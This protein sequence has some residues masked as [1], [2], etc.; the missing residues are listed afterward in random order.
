[1]VNGEDK[2]PVGRLVGC[3]LSAY[4]H[5]PERAPHQLRDRYSSFSSSMLVGGVVSSPDCLVD[6]SSHARDPAGPSSFDV[7]TFS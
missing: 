6:A 4:L 2:T 7:F 1:M 3:L 5:L